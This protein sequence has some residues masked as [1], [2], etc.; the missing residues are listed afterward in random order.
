MDLKNTFVISS[1]RR[2]LI[3]VSVL[4]KSSYF[5]SFGNSN[6]S[7]SLN[8][9]IVGTGLLNVYDNLYLL[10]TISSYNKTLH[11]ESRGIKRKINKENSTTLWH[12]RLGH[13]S[14]NRVERLVSNG[15]LDSLYFTNFNVCIECVKGKQT[16]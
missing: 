13:I 8:S 16:K 15:I 4:D 11:V 10:E 12:R 9:N 6:F 3:S 7:L 14:R 5:C 1:F 2:N